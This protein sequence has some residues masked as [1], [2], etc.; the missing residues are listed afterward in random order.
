MNKW[1]LCCLSVCLLLGVL[2]A[3]AK[4]MPRSVAIEHLL[5]PDLAIPAGWEVYSRD[6]E[7][8]ASYHQQEQANLELLRTIEGYTET[9]S[10]HVLYYEIERGAKGGYRDYLNR[11]QF[12]ELFPLSTFPELASLSFK[13]NEWDIYCY[14]LYEIDLLCVYT[15]RYGNYVINAG[16]Y[17]RHGEATYMTAAEFATAL[18]TVDDNAAKL[19]MPGDGD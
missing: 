17:L 13:A 11:R 10:Q 18:K 4:E 14:R 19:A 5:L 3:C 16:G 2:C 7:M 1:L 15:G 9:F 6:T 12:V 8:N